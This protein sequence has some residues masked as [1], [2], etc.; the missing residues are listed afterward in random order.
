MNINMNL[1]RDKDTDTNK[2]MDT[3]K[4]TTMDIRNRL[5]LSELKRGIFLK[6]H[7][8]FLIYS[9]IEAS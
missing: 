2:G 3:N 7:F 1:D 8:A 4:D 5:F 6:I 9:R